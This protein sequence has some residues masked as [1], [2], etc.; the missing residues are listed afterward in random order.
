MHAVVCDWCGTVNVSAAG[1]LV[2]NEPEP[3]GESPFT[4][5]Y[6]TFCGAD[7]LGDFVD[8]VRTVPAG[9]S[10]S[11]TPAPARLGPL[12]PVKPAAPATPVAPVVQLPAQAAEP[13]GET[14]IS[15]PEPA[16]PGLGSGLGRVRSRTAS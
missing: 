14:H 3:V 16:L 2:V 5:R 10:L 1:W 11:H 7:C 13:T 15:T 9:G 4:G 12:P 8:D 6:R